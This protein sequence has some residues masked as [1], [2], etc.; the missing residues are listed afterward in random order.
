M[1]TCGKIIFSDLCKGKRRKQ[2]NRK[3]NTTKQTTHRDG[4]CQGRKED[5][6]WSENDRIRNKIIM[7]IKKKS[8]HSYSIVN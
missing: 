3:Q 1:I 5:Q 7:I 8:F 6:I 2:N 4:Y